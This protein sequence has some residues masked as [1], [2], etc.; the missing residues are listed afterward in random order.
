MTEIS[1]EI[2]YLK[3]HS[4]LPGANELKLPRLNITSLRQN[5]YHKPMTGGQ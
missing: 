3:F 4:N 1:F 5:H 2:A